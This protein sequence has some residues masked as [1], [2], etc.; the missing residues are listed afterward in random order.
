MATAST[1]EQFGLFYYVSIK[2]RKYQHIC[3][4]VMFYIYEVS[5]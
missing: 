5:S 3:V 4:A 1:D 2:A